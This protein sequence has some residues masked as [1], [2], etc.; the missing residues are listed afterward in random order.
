MTQYDVN[1][2]RVN[3]Q[4]LRE[5]QK[6]IEAEAG[7]SGSGMADGTLVLQY[8]QFMAQAEAE[9]PNLLVKFNPQDY[10][11]HNNGGR[12]STYYR[13]SGIRAHIGRN[14]AILKVRSENLA[15]TPVIVEKSFEFI[16]DESIRSILQRDYQEVQRNMISRNW[17]SA[18]ILSGGSIEAILLD[19]IQ[20]NADLA[21][22]SD[23][24]PNEANFLKWDLSSLIDVAVDIELVGA[25]AA[26]L[27]HSVREYRNLIHPG[28][29]VRSKLKV[30]PEEA[31]IA[32][33]VLNIIIR[34]QSA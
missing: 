7:T 1:D 27:T 18:I 20:N 23:V 10:F 32:I 21:K 5:I 13:A 12:Q 31:N 15:D 19:L 29:E 34:D 26:K 9:L 4:A 2:L 8:E 30:E 33:N 24:A 6:V 3:Y 14:L 25:E 11:S 28:L 16:A 22:S 17:K